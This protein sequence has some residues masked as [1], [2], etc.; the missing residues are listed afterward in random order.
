MDFPQIPERGT[1]RFSHE[2]PSVLQSSPKSMLGGAGVGPSVLQLSKQSGEGMLGSISHWKVK[3]QLIEVNSGLKTD[4]G[5]LL[6]RLECNNMSSAHCSLR[7]LGSSDS[8]ASAS[9][10]ARTAGVR[11][12]TWLIFVFL[13]ETE[14]HHVGQAGLELLTSGHPPASASENAGITGRQSFTMWARMVLISCPHDLPALASQ[15]AEITGLTGRLRQENHLNL[16]GRGCSEPRLCHCAP[17]WVTGLT[18]VPQFHSV[19]QVRVWWQNCGSLYPLPPKLKQFSFLSLLSSC[20]YRCTPF[21]FLV[22]TRFLHVGVLLSPRLECSGVISAHRNFHFLGSI[23]LGFHYFSQAGLKL[24]TSNDLPTSASQSVEVTGHFVRLRQANHLRPGVRDQP[25]QH[26][27]T[28]SLLKIQKSAG[29]GG[30]CLQSLLLWRLRVSLCSPGWSAVMRSRLTAASAPRPEAN[31]KLLR[32]SDP[33]TYAS[34]STGIIGMNHRPQPD[35]FKFLSTGI[36]YFSRSW[37]HYTFC[38]LY[39]VLLLLPRLECN[40]L[41]WVHCNLHLPSS[42]T[43][44]LHAGQTGLKLLTSGDL[45]V[46]ASQSAEM[47]GMSHCAQPC[48]TI[49]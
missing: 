13:V 12:H 35:N 1:C 38:Q 20:D 46:S 32:S 42:K 24:L 31:L 7:L 23:E 43:G 27:E 21:T 29:C 2:L 26:G 39:G 36:G 19:T 18:L 5:S 40:G 4:R 48:S 41:I 3:F 30:A 8:S 6:P 22:E 16:D 45:P 47:T 15:S 11:H 37:I 28:L 9:P 34:P 10:V 14:F 17:P 49:H 25:G 44:L 33:P